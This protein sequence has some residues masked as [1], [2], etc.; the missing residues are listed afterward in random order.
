M[1]NKHSIITRQETT[2]MYSINLLRKENGSL[3][4]DLGSLVKETFPTVEEA[5][6]KGIL[7]TQNNHIGVEVLNT[8]T[9]EPELII[10]RH[11]FNLVLNSDL[12]DVPV[13][14]TIKTHATLVKRET[15]AY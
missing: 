6:I 1:L 3:V 14:E 5:V 11:L 13:S 7:K 4:V 10:P 15:D 9:W 8:T 2:I 12:D